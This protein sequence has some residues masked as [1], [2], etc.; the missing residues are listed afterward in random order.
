MGRANSF[1]GMTSSKNLVFASTLV[2]QSLFLS[3][4]GLMED[5]SATLQLEDLEN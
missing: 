3:A 5:G 4:T 2:A 1:Y